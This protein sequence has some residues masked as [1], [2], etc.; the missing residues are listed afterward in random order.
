MLFIIWFITH[1]RGI[2]YVS[3]LMFLEKSSLTVPA[4][5]PEDCVKNDTLFLLML[6]YGPNKLG[7]VTA[8]FA[9]ILIYSHRQTLF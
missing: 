4:L 7:G 2:N 8:L 6:F 5:S 3:Q 1:L 9:S